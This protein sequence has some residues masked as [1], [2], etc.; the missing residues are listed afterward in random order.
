MNI[1]E[2]KEFVDFVSKKHSSGTTYTPEL[3]NLNL[4]IVNQELFNYEYDKYAKT[5]NVTDTL[6]HHMV[7]MGGSSVPL[8]VDTNGFADIPSDYMH[9]SSMYYKTVIGSTGLI[10][11]IKEKRVEMLTDGEF[12]QRLGS[13]LIPDSKYACCTIRSDKIEFRPKTIQYVEFTYLKKPVKPVYDYYINLSDEETFLEEGEVHA[14]FTGEIGSDGKTK[15]PA[16]DPPYTSQTVELLFPQNV[17]T[18]LAMMLLSLV[19]INL[20]YKELLG[21]AEQI[22]TKKNNE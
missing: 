18:K 22:Q 10:P 17:H 9:K 14:W 12:S 19:G 4:P 6:R 15:N 16:T 8:K 2:L 7:T 3:L 13:Y 20:S 5:Q 21:Y 1:G 11:T